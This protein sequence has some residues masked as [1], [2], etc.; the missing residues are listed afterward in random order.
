MF[1]SHESSDVCTSMLLLSALR[2]QHNLSILDEM[3]AAMKDVFVLS[4]PLSSDL[5]TRRH[6]VD[7]PPA[8]LSR[9]T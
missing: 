9:P 5:Y 1:T 3:R 8:E 7:H 6:F 2:Q 4:V